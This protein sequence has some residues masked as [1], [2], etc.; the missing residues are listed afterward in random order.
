MRLGSKPY[1]GNAVGKDSVAML[2]LA[3]RGKKADEALIKFSGCYYEGFL[4]HTVNLLVMAKVR[5]VCFQRHGTVPERCDRLMFIRHPM[6]AKVSLVM[7]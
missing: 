6:Q 4:V 1:I 3:I 2:N 5:F 7:A